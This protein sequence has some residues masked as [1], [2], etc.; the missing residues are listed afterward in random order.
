MCLCHVTVVIKKLLI[1]HLVYLSVSNIHLLLWYNIHS[2]LCETTPTCLWCNNYL[3]VC[4]NNY[5][6]LCDRTSTCLSV[7]DYLCLCDRISIYFSWQNNHLFLC[8]TASIC[9]FYR[10]VSLCHNIHLFLCDRTSIFLSMMTIF[11]F[12]VIKINL[13]VCKRTSISMFVTGH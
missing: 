5:I 3:L 13:P 11:Y 12:S 4:D 6:C 2:F 8:D 10:T 7:N 1:L 9:F